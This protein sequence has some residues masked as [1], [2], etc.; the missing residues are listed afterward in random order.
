MS[1]VAGSMFG[2]LLQICIGRWLDDLIGPWMEEVVVPRLQT[3]FPDVPH[4]PALPL[5]RFSGSFEHETFHTG[6]D[7]LV[8]DHLRRALI[9]R[10]RVVVERWGRR[11]PLLF[12]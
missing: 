2:L 11:A 10:S 4:P 3:V 8:A 5:G 12:I 7:D 6:S 1:A 9:R